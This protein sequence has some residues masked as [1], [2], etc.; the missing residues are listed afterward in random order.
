MEN[1]IQK[2]HQKEIEVVVCITN[3][4]DAKGIKR[5]QKHNIPVEVITHQTYPTREAFDTKLVE[6]IQRYNAKLSIL[7]GFMRILTPTFTTQIDALNI[8]PSFLPQHKGA[9]AIENSFL[10]REGTGV[11]VH[12][13]SAELDGGEII[14]QQRLSTDDDTLEGYTTRLRSLEHRLYIDAIKKVLKI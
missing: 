11:S 8:H 13:V 14:L 6:V 5:A 2:M 9:N 4:V 7:A 12:R 1:I 10:S 3:K